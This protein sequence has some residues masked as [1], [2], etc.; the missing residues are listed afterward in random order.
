[1]PPKVV[2][3]LDDLAVGEVIAVEY[4]EEIS[5]YHQRLL[6]HQ[7]IAKIFKGLRPPAAG[8][9]A[10]SHATRNALYVS[11]RFWGSSACIVRVLEALE[12]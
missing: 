8:P 3:K 2:Q 5:Q 12:G 6:L 1:M 4:G 7:S 9:P 10:S 11:W